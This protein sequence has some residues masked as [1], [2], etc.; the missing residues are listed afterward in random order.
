M[1]VSGE[2][3]LG[4]KGGLICFPERKSNLCTNRPSLSPGGE[5]SRNKVGVP[6]GAP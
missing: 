3:G 5:I 2:G 6:E 4:S 1:K